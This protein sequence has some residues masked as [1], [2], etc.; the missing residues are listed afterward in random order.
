MK[1]LLC[2]FLLCPAAVA[3]NEADVTDVVV[4]CND[5]RRCSFHVTVKHRDTGWDH[6]AESWE[7]LSPEGKVLARRKLNHPHVNEQPFTRSLDGVKIPQGITEVTVRAKD[8][9][10]RY[11]GDTVTVA[12]PE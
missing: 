2:L 6:F 3:A 11:G 1:R 10:H 9:K 8:N 12:I 7:V 5:E 4:A